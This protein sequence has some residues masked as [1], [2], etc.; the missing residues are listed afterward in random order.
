MGA[1]PGHLIDRGLAD[2]LRNLGSSVTFADI[3]PPTSTVSAEIRSAFDLAKGISRAVRAASNEASLPIVLSGN[4]NASIGT[5]AG[6]RREDIAIIW[7]DAHGDYNTPETTVGGFLDGMALATLTGRCWKALAQQ[8]EGF[9][10]VSERDVVLV[11]VRDLDALE[12]DALTESAVTVLSPSATRESLGSALRAINN[13]GVRDA[14]VHIDLD[15]LD[16]SEGS[17]NSF[18]AAGGITLPEVRAALIEIGNH[19]NIRAAGITAY[20]PSFDTDGRVQRA[21]FELIGAVAEAARPE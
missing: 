17:A 5:I 8:V 7:F 12:A 20:D 6:A 19:F 3:S 13:R 9:S 10:P 16:P 1:G 14:Y 21:A 15:V 18:A 11:G 4:C 2:H